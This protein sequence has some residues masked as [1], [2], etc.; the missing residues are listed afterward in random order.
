M[1]QSLRA[2]ADARR[3]AQYVSDSY[4]ASHE[5]DNGSMSKNRT[6]S[7]NE[8]SAN[9]LATTSSTNMNN[10]HGMGSSGG[11]SSNQDVHT[12][13]TSHRNSDEFHRYPL[14]HTQPPPPPPPQQQQSHLRYNQ[15]QPL[16]GTGNNHEPKQQTQSAPMSRHIKQNSPALLSIAQAAH[17]AY[18]GTLP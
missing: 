1:Y 9:N 10:G 3:C 15:T 17:Q 14:I 4:M 8:G 2:A 16:Y 13:S 12:I 5:Q 11:L 7:S 18:S 6:D